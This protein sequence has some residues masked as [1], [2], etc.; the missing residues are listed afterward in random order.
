MIPVARGWHVHVLRPTLTGVQRSLHGLAASSRRRG[1]TA[2]CRVQLMVHA[3]FGLLKLTSCKA[4]SSRL[5]HGSR[6][7]M[8][9]RWAT[10]QSDAAHGTNT[11]PDLR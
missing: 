11:R 9:A 4:P 1:R 2:T 8:A 10:H 6:T 5:R 7:G 3:T